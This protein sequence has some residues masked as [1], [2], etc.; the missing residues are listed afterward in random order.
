MGMRVWTACV[1]GAVMV[2]TAACASTNGH[3]EA[4]RDAGAAERA[5][6]AFLETRMMTAQGGI[7][8]F[9]PITKTS[10][11]GRPSVRVEDLRASGLLSESNGM[12]MR[13]A[14]DVDDR[15]LF[16]RQFRFVK[17]WM[18]GHLGLF[19]WKISHDA[20]LTADSTAIIDDLRI[21][22]A[23]LAAG[24]KWSEEEYTRFGSEVAYNILDLES[25]D[26]LLRDFV[27]WRDWGENA[28]SPQ[29]QLSYLHLDAIRRI[30][31]AREDWK[32]LYAKNAAMLADGQ[33]GSGLFYEKFN[34]ETRR[35]E[36]TRQNTI[37]QLY[38]ALF[39]AGH[40]PN[41]RRALDFFATRWREDGAIYAEYEAQSESATKDYES[42]SV[43]ALLVRYAL[44]MNDPSLADAWLKRL[45]AFQVADEHSPLYGSF[46]DDEV[47]SFDN[48]EALL[49]LREYRD[50]NRD[51][52][53]SAAPK[54]H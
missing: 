52:T 26:G 53:G 24:E 7:Y 4:P 30:A 54:A 34:F 51:A 23:A 48:L 43:Y 11:F 28:L 22:D 15:A 47:Y 42:S 31:A 45:L 14:V 33:L 27:S 25:K 20:E 39:L 46:S 50:A 32:G 16:D 37:N 41:N 8:T 5:C 2:A 9:S 6:R 38:C 18:T 17:K 29:I 21:V 3:A 19:F 35:Y 13:Y 10:W 1:T 40:D 44:R 49:A 12:L 36:G